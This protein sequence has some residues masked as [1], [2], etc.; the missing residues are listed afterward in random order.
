MTRS[1]RQWNNKW[2]D[3]RYILKN[4]SIIFVGGLNA[5]YSVKGAIKH[6]SIFLADMK[7]HGVTIY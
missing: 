2:R 7:R 1:N 6:A 3:S 5:D 4:N